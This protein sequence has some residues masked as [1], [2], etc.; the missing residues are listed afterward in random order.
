[1]TVWPEP[2]E[3]LHQRARA[4]E[5]LDLAD[6]L[7]VEHLLGRTDLVALP[8]VEAFTGEGGDELV[9][10]HPDVPVDP[11]QRQDEAVLAEGPEPCDRVVVV[12]VDQRAV[13][14]QDRGGHG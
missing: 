1:M 7:G 6:Q 2:F 9:A 5:R 10:A 3:V 12:R 13:D 11:P 4:R 14:V 8:R